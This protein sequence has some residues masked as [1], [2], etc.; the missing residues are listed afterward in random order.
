MAGRAKKTPPTSKQPVAEPATQVWRPEEHAIG[1]AVAVILLFLVL[2][3]IGCPSSESIESYRARG[4]A[5]GREDGQRAG[6]ARCSQAAFDEAE[7]AAYSATLAELRLSG[8]AQRS[9]LYCLTAVVAGLLVGFAAQYTI[10]YLLRRPGFLSDIDWIVLSSEV[11]DQLSSASTQE[12][13]VVLTEQPLHL[14]APN[15]HK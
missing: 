14:P 15:Q 8:G 12:G 6:E 11:V 7:E 1:F 9:L 13:Q 5:A 10:F 4:M 3:I 2:V